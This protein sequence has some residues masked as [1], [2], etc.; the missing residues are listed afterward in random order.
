MINSIFKLWYLYK[1]IFVFIA[2]A[3]TYSIF[4]LFGVSRCCLLVHDHLG[5][6]FPFY[7]FYMV[8]M[9][10]S[11]ES[12]ETIICGQI[13]LSYII[14]VFVGNFRRSRRILENSRETN[15]K[16]ENFRAIW[17][18]TRHFSNISRAKTLKKRFLVFLTTTEGRA[19]S[20]HMLYSSVWS[21]EAEVHRLLQSWFRTTCIVFS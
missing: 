18:F 3:N 15:D 7:V 1:A 11:T 12:G 20:A 16:F 19:Q 21:Q 13:R 5:Y 10:S 17:T 14:P 6:I 2:R 4:L 8:Q 9:S